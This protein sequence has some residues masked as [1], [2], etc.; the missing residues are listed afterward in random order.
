M[1][2]LLYFRGYIFLLYWELKPRASCTQAR[3]VL[4]QWTSPAPHTHTHF[5]LRQGLTK[6][7]RLALNLWCLCLIHL[8]R[9]R[10]IDR[11]TRLS[12]VVDF[13]TILCF[14]FLGSSIM[15]LYLVSS[16]TIWKYRWQII[17]HYISL[18]PLDSML[19]HNSW[20][21]GSIKPGNYMLNFFLSSQC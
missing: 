13:E 18:T 16:Q 10:I 8:S 6:L 19:V 14:A 15:V 12:S 21:D 9:W 20:L 5:I 2:P 1:Y 17:Y 3:Q 4:Y 11:A 7:T